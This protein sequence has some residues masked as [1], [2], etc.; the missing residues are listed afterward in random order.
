M[1]DRLAYAIL[2]KSISVYGDLDTEDCADIARA[3]VEGREID[4]S[5]YPPATVEELRPLFEQ[6]DVSLRR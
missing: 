2:C 5:C 1:N 3:V 4:W 6:H